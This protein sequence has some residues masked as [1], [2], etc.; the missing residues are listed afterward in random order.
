[1]AA[2]LGISA[3]AVFTMVVLGGVTRL[4]RSGLSMVD[5][6]PQGSK[7]PGTT[8]EW[9]V[10]FEKY[11]QFPE[12]KRV[13]SVSQACRC[14]PLRPRPGRALSPPPPPSLPPLRR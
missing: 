3:A 1:M 13:N 11:K 9:E 2:W 6:R 7:L 10:E 4:T 5:W 8:E 12:F 14:L